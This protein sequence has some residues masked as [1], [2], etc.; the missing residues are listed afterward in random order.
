MISIL[1]FNNSTLAA[2]LTIEVIATLATL[3]YPG[4]VAVSLV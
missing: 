4:L 3:A 2:E 1:V